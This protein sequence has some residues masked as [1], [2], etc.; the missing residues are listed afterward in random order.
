MLTVAPAV[1][2]GLAEERL[3]RGREMNAELRLQ[4]A[5]FEQVGASDL[6]AALH[7]RGELRAQ[8]AALLAGLDL[9]AMP[10]TLDPPP[11]LPAP[12]DSTPTA[13]EDQNRRAC[14]ITFLANL[15]GLPAGTA[16]VGLSGGL[17]VGLQLMGDAFD[18]AS[19][20]AGLAAVERAGMADGLHPPG[21]SPIDS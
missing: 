12:R 4:L 3:L 19:V 5:M 14:Q 10:T 18:E 16:P 15:T 20:I 6:A 21:W 2:G 9:L 7:L 1:L 17:P 13:L 11:A 8:T